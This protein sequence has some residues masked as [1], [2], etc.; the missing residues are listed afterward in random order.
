[1]RAALAAANSGDTIGFA[2]PNASTIHLS[3]GTLNVATAVNIV[4]PGPSALNVQGNGQFGDFFIQ[5]SST[6][7]G[8]T[9]SGGGGNTGGGIFNQSILTLN[10]CVVTNN[11]VT[12]EGGGI[13]NFGDLYITNCLLSHNSCV[14]QGGG[15]HCGFNTITDIIGCTFSQNTINADSVTARGGAVYNDGILLTMINSTFTQNQANGVGSG[16]GGDAAGGGIYCEGDSSFTMMNCTLDHNQAQ[17]G[18]AFNTKGGAGLGGGLY[19]TGT[20]T[21]TN[22]TFN[23]NVAEGGTSQQA[24][25]GFALGGGIDWVDFAQATLVNCTIDGNQALGGTGSFFG[26]GNG[27]GLATNGA[28]TLA[29]SIV[30][31]DEG[32]WPDIAGGLT[33]A[34][35]DLVGNGAGSNVM[36]GGSL[37]NQVGSSGSPIDPHL[38]LLQNNGGPTLTMLPLANSTAINRGSNI[39][40]QT[41]IDQRGLPRVVAGT[42]DIGAV[43]VQPPPASAP[44]V[45]TDFAGTGIW[46]S[47]NGGPYQNI[48]PFDAQQVAV[49]NQGEVFA[50]FDSLGT[51]YTPSDQNHWKELDARSASW[52]GVD[53]SGDLLADFSGS[54]LFRFAASTL[55]TGAPPVRLT[56]ADASIISMDYSTG[57]FVAEFTGAG[58]W[59]CEPGL[60][61]GNPWLQLKL[62]GAAKDANL[63]R[64]D[65][66]N[67]VFAD[68]PGTGLWEYTDAAHWQNLNHTDAAFISI[69]ENGNLAA[70]LNGQGLWRYEQGSWQQ[71]SPSTASSLA[72]DQSG[73]VAAEFKGHGCWLYGSSWNQLTSVDAGAIQFDVNDNL[74]ADLTGFGTWLYSAVNGWVHL[75][76]QDASIYALNS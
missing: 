15:L 72:I 30:A 45:V 4:G 50:R 42:V 39:F 47:R 66:M 44:Y 5:A 53:G 48:L 71:L 12:T 52:I 7:S 22:C 37:G 51:W 69:S 19:F 8:L 75:G 43:E 13:E 2:L 17:G 65:S 64:I 57:N 9:I 59:R 54:G 60:L 62:N 24:G 67:D 49:D 33:T 32:F 56:P 38:G 58:V 55:A 41:T 74:F 23:L 31:N 36:V 29:N 76:N 27:G 6:I 3:S 34:M 68:F 10:N 14:T 61:P 40:L 16:L 20:G 73:N 21:L 1:L 28:G 63:V 18:G 35:F 25:G 70:D 11:T 26:I 46:I